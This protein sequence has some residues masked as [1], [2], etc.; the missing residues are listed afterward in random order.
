MITLYIIISIILSF[1]FRGVTFPESDRGWKEEAERLKRRPSFRY[2]IDENNKKIKVPASD[3]VTEWQTKYKE[4]YDVIMKACD[5]AKGKHYSDGR[6]HGDDFCFL[7]NNMVEYRKII[8]EIV[9]RERGSQPEYIKDNEHYIISDD[10]EFIFMMFNALYRCRKAL[11]RDKKDF[12]YLVN[13][14]PMF[15]TNAYGLPKRFT[16]VERYMLE[17]GW[18]PR[19]PFALNRLTGPIVKH[20]K[21]PFPLVDKKDS[22]KNYKMVGFSGFAPHPKK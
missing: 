13:D 1:K 4:I 17:N 5:N 20:I 18:N 11:R 7:V 9:C 21:E 3:E 10:K 6:L 8:A 12:S 15:G 14:H 22:I 16:D 19:I 2:V